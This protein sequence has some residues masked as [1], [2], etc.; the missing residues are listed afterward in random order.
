MKE[1]IKLNIEKS[2]ILKHKV[3]SVFKDLKLNFKS[4]KSTLINIMDLLD[5]EFKWSK[6]ICRF[7]I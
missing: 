1:V 2:Y 3:I 6:K 4:G 7:C 5:N